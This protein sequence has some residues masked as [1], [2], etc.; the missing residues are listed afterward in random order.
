[1]YAHVKLNHLAVHLKLMQ[2]C[3]STTFQYKIKIEKET[4]PQRR[5]RYSTQILFFSFNGIL[6]FNINLFIFIGV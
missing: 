2:H 6:F 4:D 5:P 1:M 3:K